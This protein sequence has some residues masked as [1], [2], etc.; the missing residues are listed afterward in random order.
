MAAARLSTAWQRAAGS[1]I[2]LAAVMLTIGFLYWARPI[3]VPI[4]LA[5]LLAFLLSPLVSWLQR[6]G[7]P[8]VPAV[9]LVTAWAG[10]VIAVLSWVFFAQVLHLAGQLPIYQENVTRRISEIRDQGRGS[11]FTKVQRFVDGVMY[12]ATRPEQP[13]VVDN[14]ELPQPVVL[15]GRGGW[16]LT[17]LFSALGPAVEPLATAGL[18]VILFIYSLVE[19]ESL[20][21]RLLRL[22]GQGHMT[23]TTRALDEA[24]QRISRYLLAQFLLN[25]SFGI[26]IACGLWLVGLPHAPLWGFLAAFLRY[27]P[28]LGPWLAAILPV[29]LSL[30]TAPGWSQPI[31]VVL[32]FLTFELLSNLVIEPLVYGHSIGVSQAS[33]IV[34]I[35]FWAWLWGPLGLV[36]AA[37][38]TVCLVIL[39]KYVPVLKFFDVLLGDDPPLA[40]DVRFYQRILAG[41]HDEAAEVARTCL[42]KTSLE[43][44][45]DQLLIPALS[46]TRADLEA[47]RLAPEEAQIIWTT[48][49]EIA[50]ELVL[51]PAG[52][53]SV[54]CQGTP[55]DSDP[56]SPAKRIRIL[57]CAARD[58]ADEVA[59]HLFARLLDPRLVELETSN[60]DWLASEVVSQ[61]EQ[62]RPGIVCIA[63]LPPGGLAHTR[64]LC[65]RLRKRLPQIMIV[66]GR[67]GL[68]G[69]V[70]GNRSQISES[71][72]DFVG[73]T[74]QETCGQVARLVQF[75][76]SSSANTATL[77]T[78]TASTP[79]FQEANN[80][81][82]DKPS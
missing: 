16:S 57:A 79:H 56:D 29:S 52:R 24:G 5:A 40:G 72:A 45:Y 6:R 41:D 15:V 54:E 64:L 55:N 1:L 23:M 71:G 18:V 50:E 53:A 3:L 32:L 70:E 4:A 35:A 48:A 59:M 66:V 12:A 19:R 63:A 51:A 34:A 37:P 65:K 10:I 25:A 68:T 13:P 43:E 17:P 11:L 82:Y 81:H 27:I 8:R 60:T 77:R 26:V 9:L 2:T 22:V 78:I 75:L 39:G 14:G 62:F 76:R 69:D 44:V 42:Q 31:L 58:T 61:V 30:M 21:D 38:L 33:L 7:L 46:Y 20:R 28:F 49:G 74:M 67:W 36:L 80:V 47:D 73:I